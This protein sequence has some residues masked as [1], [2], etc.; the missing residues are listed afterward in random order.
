MAYKTQSSDTSREI[1]EIRFAALRKMTPAEKLER[2]GQLGALL[3]ELAMADIRRRHADA[4][5]EELRLRL[6][7]RWL[8]RETMIDA[9]GFDPEGD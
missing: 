4:G 2:V 5:E 8:D 3:R 6:A 9:Y 1:E 7:S